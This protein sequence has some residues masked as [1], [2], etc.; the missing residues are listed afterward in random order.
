MRLART[1][2]SARNPRHLSHMT[3]VDGITSTTRVASCSTTLLSRR[4]G[5]RR[6]R[7]FVNWVSGKL[8]TD[9][10]ARSCWARDG[11]A[12]TGV[13]RTSPSTAVGWSYRSTNVKPTGLFLQLGGT[14]KFVD[15]CN[16][17]R[18]P[19]RGGTAGCME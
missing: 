1:G 4:R 16:N 3:S 6:L 5:P 15:L 2:Q 19:Q 18:A 14:A 8:S 7:S 13:T 10:V 17:R 11:S 12:S 9:P